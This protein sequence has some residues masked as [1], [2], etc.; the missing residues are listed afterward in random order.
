MI[1]FESLREKSFRK[2][3]MFISTMR[4]KVLPMAQKRD[5]N[6]GQKHYLLI[7]FV[8]LYMY[9]IYSSQILTNNQDVRIF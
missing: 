6:D 9:V 5:L 7:L 2:L 4:L 1:F 8:K 3:S